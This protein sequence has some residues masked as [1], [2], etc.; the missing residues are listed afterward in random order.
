[1]N[2]YLIVSLRLI[3]I[4]ILLLF[5]TLFIMGKRPIGELPVFD[6]LAIIVLGS[7]VGADIADPNTNHWL[8]V[9]SVVILALLQ[10][11]V[12]VVSLKSIKLRKLVNFEPTIVIHN[13]L[14]VIKNL[15]KINYTMDE[16]VMLL[17]E[18][19]IFDINIV[20]YAIIEA[21]G[22]ISVLKKAEYDPVTLQNMNLTIPNVSL[23]YTI[24]LEGKFDE[25]NIKILN[26]SKEH[27]IEKLKEKGHP[28]HKKIFYVSMDIYE[29]MVICEYNDEKI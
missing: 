26:T 15:K 24:L 5:S 13:G 28:D 1:M 17:R 27:L 11:I 7:V 14:V 21:S 3:S 8:I 4:M 20:S 10:R 2:L 6:F 18:K 22:K 12:S 19:D 9:L 25:K 29:N 16:L 23:P